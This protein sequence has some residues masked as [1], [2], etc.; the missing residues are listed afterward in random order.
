MSEGI[1]AAAAG[2]AAQQMQMDAIGNDIANVDTNG[3]HSERVGFR[4]L[5]YSSEDGAP[6]GAGTAPVDLGRTQ[7]EGALNQTGDP[8]SLAIDG[9]GYFQVRQA[10]G[11][12]ALTRDGEFTTDATGALV[13]STG[14]KLV[15]P[16]TLPKGTDPSDVKITEDGA[17]TAGGKALGKVTVVDV[18]NPGGLL[19]AGDNLFTVTA[20]SGAAAPAKGSKVEQGAVE[21][22]NVDLGSAM[23]EM[24]QAQRGYQLASNAIKTQDELLNVANQLVKS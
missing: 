12:V 6:V 17:V 21:S 22:S 7:T 1:Y 13:T 8:L 20:Q 11:S 4:D 19:S 14:Q 3:Y 9:P 10:D 18:T 5:M 15:P 2:M 23:V 16:I 24:I